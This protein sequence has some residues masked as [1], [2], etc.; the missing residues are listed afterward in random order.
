MI[1][2][3][4]IGLF[5]MAGLGCASTGTNS[6]GVAVISQEEYEA[7][8]E[9]YSKRTEKYQG[10]LNTLHLRGTLLN[11][12]VLE[13]Q[14]LQK[15]RLYQWD[16]GTYNTEREKVNQDMSRASQV[17]ISLYTPDRKHDNLDRNQTMW[18]IFLDAGGRRF[19]GSVKKI[20]LLPNEVQ[21]LYPDHTRFGTPYIVTFP[22]PM[23]SIE[24][25][26]PRFTLTGTVDSATLQF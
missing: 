24:G 26:A 19:E 18:K 10:L 14:L 15:A 4:L 25:Q 22:V 8:I 13:S 11:S 21:A 23:K 17:F 12:Q 3:L 6:F 5:L 1:R 20:K 2:S 9:P 16:E 7:R